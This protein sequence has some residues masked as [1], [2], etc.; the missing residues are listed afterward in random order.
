MPIF[1]QF[2]KITRN[3][4]NLSWQG[5]NGHILDTSKLSMYGHVFKN[6][7]H[8]RDMVHSKGLSP[9]L[10]RKYATVHKRR[11]LITVLSSGTWCHI[12]CHEFTQVLEGHT[13][14][15]S[16]FKNK[17]SNRQ[18]EFCGQYSCAKHRW[19]CKRPHSWHHISEHGHCC[20][21]FTSNVRY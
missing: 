1:Q 7:E 4:Y 17:P 13:A 18:L 21:S 20:D 6:L 14:P 16:G 9:F 5:A 2:Y 12:V 8:G 11:I 10:Y 15:S 3:V 19:S